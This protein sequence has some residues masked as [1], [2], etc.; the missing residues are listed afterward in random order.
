MASQSVIHSTFVIERSFPSSPERV[1]AAFAEP[2][3]KRRWMA[4]ARNMDVE[5]FEMDFRIGGKERSRYRFRQGSPFPG[6]ALSN[7]TTYLDIV[8][9]RRVV[10]AYTMTLG[11]KPFSASLATFELLPAKNGTDLLFTEQGAYFE[12]SDGPQRREEGWRKLLESLAAELS[13]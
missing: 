10:V 1:F 4:E 6:A 13:R 11:D 2:G 8:P 7:D 3:K 9:N 5:Q 12:G